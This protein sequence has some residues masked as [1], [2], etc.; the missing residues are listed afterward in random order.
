MEHGS[1]YTIWTLLDGA[2]V[3]PVR[4]RNSEPTNG[5]ALEVELDSSLQSTDSREKTVE[6]WRNPA[7]ASRARGR[8]VAQR[9]L[10]VSA[11]EFRRK[12]P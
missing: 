12:K 4:F 11:S 6:F 1:F 8:N 5:L 9:W 7:A 2:L 3:V 10:F